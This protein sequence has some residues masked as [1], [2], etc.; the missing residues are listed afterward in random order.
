MIEFFP[1]DVLARAI[2][3]FRLMPSQGLV[4]N[5]RAV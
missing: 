3:K 1:L 2:M 5:E 4:G